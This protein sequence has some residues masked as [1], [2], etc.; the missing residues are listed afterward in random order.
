MIRR[1]RFAGTLSGKVGLAVLFFV[2]AVAIFGP[3]VSPHEIARP[4]GA[5]GTPPSGSALLGTDFL[6]RDVLSRVL[7]GGLSVVWMGSAATLLGYSGG[8]TIGLVAGYQ[9]SLIDPVLMRAVDVLLAF[10]ALLVLLLLVAGLG[11]HVWVLIAGVALVQLPP[12][13]RIIRTATLEVS[14]RGYIEAAQARGE[15]TAVILTREIVPN[16][17]PVVLADFGIRFGFSIILIASVNYLGLGL[18][19]PAADWGLMIAENQQYISLNIWSVLAPAIM[20]A[21]LT[22]SVNLIADAYVQTLGRSTLPVRQ[23]RVLERI[24]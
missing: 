8:M 13:A 15:R 9:R 16:L 17:A 4:I 3:L 14:T 1:P 18:A 5:P 2:L 23:R 22:I 7:H 12:I 20:L 11:S 19:P 21:L 10:P 24:R 6:G